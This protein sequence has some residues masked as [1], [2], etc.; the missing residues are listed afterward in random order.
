MKLQKLWPYT[1]FLILVCLFLWKPIFRG[2]ALL[3]GDYLAQMSPW[4]SVVR[5]SDPAPQWNPLAWDAIAQFYPWRVF[6]AR[7]M[8]SGHIPLWNPHQFSG[9]PFL[10]NG[11]SA[12]LYPLNVVFLLFDPITA[13]TVFAAL[14]L[15]LAQ[16]FMFWLLREL[17]CKVLG[18]VVGAI[19]FAFS[20][21]IVLWLELPTFVAVAVWLPLVLLLTHRSV[22][23][24]SLPYAAY[25]GGSLALCILAGHLQ[26]ACYVT[27]A[28]T[29]WWLWRLAG[30][31][32]SEGGALALK[33]VL[34]AIA[35]FVIVAG[36][37]GS[38]QLLPSMELAANSPRSGG[39]TAAGYDWFIG[40]SLKPYRLITAFAPDFYGNGSLDGD[41]ALCDMLGRHAGSAADYMEYGMYVGILPLIL[42]LVALGRV[43]K[44][45]HVGFFA[46]LGVF[47]L[48]IALGTAL[49]Y[50]FYFFVPGFSAFGGPNRILLLYVFSVAA[51]AGFGADA[52][53][54]EAPE[55]GRPRRTIDAVVVCAII[56]AA[57]IAAFLPA[58]EM[59]YDVV[60]SAGG[61]DMVWLLFPIVCFSPV[62]AASAALVLL[63]VSSRSPGH[64][65]LLSA[66]MVGLVIA[67]LFAFGINYNPTCSR[68]KVYPRT[69]LTDTLKRIAPNSRIAPV[70]PNW[71]LWETPKAIL[72]PNSAMV[73]GLYD[74]QGYDSLY[75][76]AYKDSF[77][78]IQGID[79]SPP[80]NGNMILMRQYSQG[81]LGTASLILS[82]EPIAGLK[83]IGAYDGI[84]V[85]RGLGVVTAS[86]VK[87]A[88]AYQPFSF[89][90]GLFLSMLGL[91]VLCGFG[92]YSRLERGERSIDKA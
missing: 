2:D 4:N 3:P 31:W 81:A 53:N 64:R 21:F 44:T 11:Q 26:I 76:K 37:I 86:S 57:F 61:D 42:A 9:T 45:R 18:G 49:N 30:V 74:V 25:A 54:A 92:A 43:R 89:R 13:F 52:L 85:L 69:Q 27:L 71:S 28:A 12:V 72:P 23:R 16:V 1:L 33:R 6:Y 73:Y 55:S 48:L 62:F 50:V 84:R 90:L 47:S 7:S 19:V 35:V 32:K 24:K 39:P 38:A 82:R 91:A 36:L 78:R 67:D 80:E 34:P 41:Y 87:P 75:P 15:L 79:C 17:G 8:A 56:V 51:L 60:L 63:T 10:A 65:S 20:A 66:A 14:H 22:E 88:Q 68:D 77:S 59:V 40:N 29:F 83:E 58:R 5:S 46:F 70:N